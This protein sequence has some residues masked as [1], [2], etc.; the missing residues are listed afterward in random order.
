MYQ[1]HDLIEKLDD[2]I[3]L[4]LKVERIFTYALGSTGDPI[5]GNGHQIHHASEK[6]SKASRE[7]SYRNVL[8]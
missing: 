5:G 1:T 4:I 7:K 2:V 8:L 3:D 6:Y